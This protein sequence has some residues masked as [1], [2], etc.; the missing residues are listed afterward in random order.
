[1]SDAAARLIDVHDALLLDL[2]GV[3]YLSKEPV[4]GAVEAISAAQEAGVACLYVTNNANRPAP[5]VAEQLRG[6]G[7]S[8]DDDDIV[9]SAQVAARLVRDTFG[10]SATVLPIGGPGVRLA[11]EQVG[12]G[13]VASATEHP[14]AVM[15]GYGPDVN[16]KDLAEASY[17]INGGARYVAT[18]TDLTIPTSR[19][20]APGNGSL[21]AA[22]RLAIKEDPLVAGKPEPAPFWQAAAR[23]GAENPLVIGDR[24]DTDILGGNRAGYTTLMVL[25]GVHGTDDLLAADADH[26]PTLI[27]ADLAALLTRPPH[28]VQLGEDFATCGDA[29]V[30][31]VDDE[32][33]LDAEHDHVDP[34]QALRAACALSWR[35]NDRA[36]GEESAA[37]VSISPRLRS[38][39]P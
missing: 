28:E 33:I 34:V 39:L 7:L 36:E 13:M 18:N 29:R 31:R 14:T 19:G 3:V 37:R 21:V 20:I 22:V 15:Q 38:L 26:R 11:L 12:L 5:E 1:M 25:T 10:E 9:T 8:L 2:D 35:E 17:A 24:L 27:S 6:F 4:P 23:A 16:W 30:R 32:I